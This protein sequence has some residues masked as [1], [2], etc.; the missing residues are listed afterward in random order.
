MPQAQVNHP[1]WGEWSQ[2]PA[3]VKEECGS[4]LRFLAI[5]EQ[6][7]LPGLIA[8]MEKEA[9][10]TMVSKAND[11]GRRAFDKSVERAPAEDP[12][13]WETTKALLSERAEYP[14][15]RKV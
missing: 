3:S 6:G 9:T 15:I 10:E 8:S 2:L 11:E 7:L 1:R 14:N 4:F 12:E 5:R 13:R